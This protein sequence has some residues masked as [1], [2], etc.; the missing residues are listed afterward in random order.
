[1]K[2]NAALVVAFLCA[3]CFIMPWGAFVSDPFYIHV[4]SIFASFF[5]VS[6]CYF[7]SRA[8]W[9]VA[10]QFVE[11]ACVIYQAQV[12]INWDNPVDQYYIYH[13]QFMLCA[14]ILELLFV[15]ASTNKFMVA[16]DGITGIVRH[17]F[18]SIVRVYP[19]ERRGFDIHHDTEHRQC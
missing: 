15:F 14:F 9:A 11:I 8:W 4:V 13:D 17:L 19:L 2:K 5:I 12:W 6:S 10:V 3:F 7:I 1:M 16:W 18:F